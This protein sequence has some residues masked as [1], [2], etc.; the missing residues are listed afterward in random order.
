MD[1][2]NLRPVPSRPPGRV[3]PSDAREHVAAELPGLDEH[4][5]AALALVELAGRTH[6]AAAAEAE[7]PPAELATALAAARTALRRALHPLPGSG[8]CG[9]A[10][11]LLSDRIDGELGAHGDKLLDVHIDNCPRCVEHDLRL[12]QARDGLMR[13]FVEAHDTAAAV[14]EV[15]APAP[16][17]QVVVEEPETGPVAEVP[18]TAPPATKEPRS[19]PVLS[20]VAEAG[21]LAWISAAGLAVALTILSVLIVIL[22]IL[23][24]SINF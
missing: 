5:V 7:L 12:A 19:A 21:G 3:D 13:R 9:R 8:W 18:E 24:A 10:E 15:V 1:R 4:A 11:R 22:G 17:L 2:P 14:A 20:S 16:V 23:G 6:A